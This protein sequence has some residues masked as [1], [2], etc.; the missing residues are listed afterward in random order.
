MGQVSCQRLLPRVIVDFATPFVLQSAISQLTSPPWQKP[1]PQDVCTHLEM[2]VI[3]ACR[4]RACVTP[5]VEF[6][7]FIC[8]C[9]NID[10]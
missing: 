4:H 9:G 3:H 7:V 6:Y 5:C 2:P 1:N 8:E 10:L